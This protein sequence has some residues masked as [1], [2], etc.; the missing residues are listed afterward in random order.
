MRRSC[1]QLTF[2]LELIYHEGFHY[3]SEANKENKVLI[4]G[5]M[6]ELG[7]N[8]INPCSYLNKNLNH[9]GG[10]RELRLSLLDE[11]SQTLPAEPDWESFI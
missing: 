11:V 1:C 9:G 7:E 2:S 4:L 6:F 5:D 3:I 10:I 8:S